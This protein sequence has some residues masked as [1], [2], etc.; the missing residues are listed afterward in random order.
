MHI[1]LIGEEAALVIGVLGVMSQK[2]GWP[3]ASLLDLDCLARPVVQKGVVVWGF[4]AKAGKAR[5]HIFIH[6]FH[7]SL[8]THANIPLQFEFRE[9]KTK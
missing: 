5:K 2:L 9:T 1:D 6:R 3:I 7:E 8:T 4:L